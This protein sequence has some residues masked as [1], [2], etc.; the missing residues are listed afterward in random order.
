MDLNIKMKPITST[1]LESHYQSEDLNYTSLQAQ[2]SAVSRRAGGAS[3]RSEA[4]SGGGSSVG[5]GSSGGSDAAAVDDGVFLLEGDVRRAPGNRRKVCALLQAQGS[6][7]SQ[8]AGGA[9]IGPSRPGGSVGAEG[10]DER[11][12]VAREERGPAL[13]HPPLGCGD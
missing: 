2:G 12:G 13:R 1:S 4:G 8:R 9:R 3:A 10:G 11:S 5:A 6:A 7:V